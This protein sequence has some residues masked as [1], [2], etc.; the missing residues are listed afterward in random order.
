MRHSI[1]DTSSDSNPRKEYMYTRTLCT[2]LSALVCRMKIAARTYPTPT[3]DMKVPRNANIRIDPK[4]LKKFSYSS[5]QNVYTTELISFHTCFNS[6]PELRMI[7]GSSKLKKRVC[8]NVYV[9]KRQHMKLTSPN[10]YGS[11]NP[12]NHICGRICRGNSWTS[13]T[14]S[15]QTTIEE[16]EVHISKIDTGRKNCSTYP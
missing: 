7:G 14:T 6:Y 16:P 1:K 3:A 12:S 5:Y 8:L 2:A 10:H 4:F 15:L 9:D 13:Q 11:Y